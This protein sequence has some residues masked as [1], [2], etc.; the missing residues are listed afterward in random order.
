MKIALSEDMMPGMA[1][2]VVEFSSGEYKIRMI[3]A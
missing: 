3:F 2:R 1:I